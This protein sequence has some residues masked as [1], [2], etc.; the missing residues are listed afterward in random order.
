[1]LKIYKPRMMFLIETKLDSRR[2]E[3]F[4]KRCGCNNSIEVDAEG[5][6]G[7]LCLAWLDDLTVE[8]RSFL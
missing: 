6:C 4:R 8:F 1:M 3:I 5:S 7:G 2:M